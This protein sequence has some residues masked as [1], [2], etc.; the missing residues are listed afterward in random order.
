V[1]RKTKNH[2][3][4]YFVKEDFRL[5]YRGRRNLEKSIEEEYIVELQDSC[6]IEKNNRK[7]A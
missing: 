4:P 1:Q 5:D 3:I 6:W 7:Y 2:K